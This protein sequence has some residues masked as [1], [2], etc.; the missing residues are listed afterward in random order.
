[1]D[2]MPEA[3]EAKQAEGGEL[4]ERDPHQDGRALAV[5]RRNRRDDAGWY[6][7]VGEASRVATKRCAGETRLM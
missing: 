4:V 2:T 5:G 1:M 7:P 3:V 6:L